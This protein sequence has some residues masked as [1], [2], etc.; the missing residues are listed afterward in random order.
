MLLKRLQPM[1][2][3]ARRNYVELMFQVMGR[4]LQAISDVDEPTREE[5]RAL[6]EGFLFEMQVMPNGP[7]LIV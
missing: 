7:K 4:A 3:Q 5:V 1:M 6:P 2:F